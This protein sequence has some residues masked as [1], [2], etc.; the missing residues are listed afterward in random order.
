MLYVLCVLMETPMRTPTNTQEETTSLLV[1]KMK[2]RRGQE[3]CETTG[4]FQAII[5][6]GSCEKGWPLGT[7]QRQAPRMRIYG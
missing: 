1:L 7:L 4:C 6:Q 5:R 3:W 2:E